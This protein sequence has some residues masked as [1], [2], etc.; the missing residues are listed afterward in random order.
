MYILTTWKSRPITPEQTNRMMAIWGRQE[1][2]LAADA[3]SER[4]CWFMNVDGSG[5]ILVIK[6]KDADAAIAKGLA[7]SLALGVF[8][9][10][11]SEIVLD[12]ESA[13]PS[14][15]KGIEEVNAK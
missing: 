11:R 10:L 15:I 6:V 9:E 2:A 14:I 5:G 4:V 8:L 7:D 3:T 12:L 1:A 13:M